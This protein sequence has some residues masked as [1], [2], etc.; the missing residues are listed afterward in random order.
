[1]RRNKEHTIA[2]YAETEA[3]F[4]DLS[5]NYFEDYTLDTSMTADYAKNPKRRK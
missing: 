1:M 3:E 5:S 2:F 4:V